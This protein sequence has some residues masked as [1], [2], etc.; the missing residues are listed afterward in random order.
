MALGVFGYASLVSAASAGETLGREVDPLPA[1]LAGWRRRWSLG[2]DN[3]QA[4]KTFA[5]V[6][7]GELPRVCLGLNIE[8]AEEGDEA[9]NGA[10]I[11]LS[12]AELDRLD[13]REIRYD[14]VDVT[15]AID[16]L[17][18]GVERVVTYRAKPERFLASTPPGSVI[19]AAYLRAI[20]E[21]FDD[22]GPGQLDAF[23]RTTGPPPAPV[24]EGVLVRDEI[25]AGNPRTW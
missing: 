18:D 7:G 22:L 5:R 10:V 24:V 17:P 1:T 4:E 16:S 15:A 23:R 12:A 14:R 19:I 13:V 11:E 9:P 21:A 2:R 20:E 8:P 3:L 25:P 6:D